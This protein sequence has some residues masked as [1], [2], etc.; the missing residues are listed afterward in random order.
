MDMN[1]NQR[2][3]LG[4]SQEASRNVVVSGGNSQGCAL[5]NTTAAG[6]G[7]YLRVRKNFMVFNSATGRKVKIPRTPFSHSRDYNKQ[8]GPEISSKPGS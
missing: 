2:T 3:I 4:F 7:F 1:S 5:T 6:E 8:D